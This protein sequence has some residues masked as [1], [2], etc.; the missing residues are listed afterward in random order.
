MMRHFDKLGNVTLSLS[1][2]DDEGNE[3]EDEPV[4]VRQGKGDISQFIEMPH[5]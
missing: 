3:V 5:H 1:L 4:V 2:T